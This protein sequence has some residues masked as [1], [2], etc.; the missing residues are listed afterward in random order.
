M[1]PKKTFSSPVHDRALV[2]AVEK[3]DIVGLKEALDKGADPN[4]RD[5]AT[6]RN[7]LFTILDK[8]S[9]EDGRKQEGSLWAQFF[10]LQHA[11]A[12]AGLADNAGVTPLHY[13]FEKRDAM[14]VSVM[15]LQEGLALNTPDPRTG[16]TPLHLSLPLFLEGREDIDKTPFEMLAAKG[17][18]PA[19]PDN[20][21]L[22]ALDIARASSAEKASAAVEK[23]L[24]TPVMKQRRLHDRAKGQSLKLKHP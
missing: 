12:D 17:A 14:L 10:A 15:L 21:G 23:M 5:P 24:N 7:L 22:S 8:V 18:D 2:K 9:T 11:G 1:T 16:E 6:G 4:V 13:G 3:S 20:A 19:V